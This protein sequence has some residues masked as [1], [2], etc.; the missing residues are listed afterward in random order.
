MWLTSWV[1]GPSARLVF[2][3]SWMRQPSP[4]LHSR[5]Q[6]VRD[7]QQRSEFSAGHLSGPPSRPG[8]W[9]IRLGS[10][11]AAP[12]CRFCWRPN[13]QN[14]DYLATRARLARFE[15]P[16]Q[17]AVSER[18]PAGCRSSVPHLLECRRPRHGNPRTTSL[19]PLP[20]S[21]TVPLLTWRNRV[22]PPR[23]YR[24]LAV[25]F[26]LAFYS[27]D[28]PRPAPL[29]RSPGWRSPRAGSG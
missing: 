15:F 10:Q 28:G 23:C 11:T 25:R 2:T 26:S 19:R 3:S 5:G 8:V 24:F 14:S 4:V 13:P 22:D 29:H 7:E 1:I 20:A 9:E 6:E 18:P 16:R 12:A 21:E 17:F 27:P